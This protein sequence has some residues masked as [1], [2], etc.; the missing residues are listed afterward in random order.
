MNGDNR[1]NTQNNTHESEDEEDEDYEMPLLYVDVTLSADLKTRIAL[2]E[3]DDVAE[4]AI[5]FGKRYKLD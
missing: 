4:I 2:Y 5:E 3:G 1:P